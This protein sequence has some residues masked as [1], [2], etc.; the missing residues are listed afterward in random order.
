MHHI[1]L[2]KGRSLNTNNLNDR[3]REACTKIQEYIENSLEY[4]LQIYAFENKQVSYY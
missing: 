3:E 1:S 4:L 2:D